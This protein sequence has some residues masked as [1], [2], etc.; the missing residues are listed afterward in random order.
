MNIK[1]LESLS[2]VVYGTLLN[3]SVS[4]AALAAKAELAPYKGASKAPVLYVKPRNTLV[5]S[6]AH[7]EVPSDVD[8]LEIGASLGLVIGRVACNVNAEQA[9]SY[10]AGYV[11]VNDVSVPHDVFYRPSVRLKAR[12]GFC[13]I[14]PTV[15][16]ADKVANPDSL[17]VDVF[18]DDVLVHST[19]TGQRRRPVAQLIADVTEFMTLSPGDVLMLG[20]SAGAPTA[21]SGQRVRLAI[22]HLGELENTF[23]AEKADS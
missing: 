1:H 18:V 9:L 19:S 16:S 2:G 17:K 6:G 10:V 8:Q 7:I 20:V 13:P 5:G 14:G 21:R 4:Y 23:I 3:H 22:E 11:I 12:D 15:V